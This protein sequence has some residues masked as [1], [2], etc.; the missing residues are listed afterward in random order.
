MR[1]YPICLVQLDRR[2][3]VVVGGGQVAARKVEALL[4]AGAAVTVISPALDPH[5]EELVQTACVEWLCRAY[6]DGDLEGAFL[7]I[8]ATDNP[9]VNQAVWQEAERRGCLVNVVDEP[10]RCNFIVPAVVRRGEVLAALTTGGASPALAHRLRQRLEAWLT[11]GYADLA[12]ILAELRPELKRR[13]SP[14]LRLP[15]ALYLIDSDLLD[16]TETWGP[17]AGLAHA[18]VLLD[19]FERLRT[20]PDPL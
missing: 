1:T 3:S 6:Q 4:A 8:S 18:R 11:P 7:V 13:F 9:D 5:L 16:L 15:A 2:R 20:F 17:A 10:E 14:E 12:A 19:E